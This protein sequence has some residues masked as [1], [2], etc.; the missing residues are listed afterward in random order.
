MVPHK[1]LINYIQQKKD[2]NPFNMQVTPFDTV[3]FLFSIA[4]NGK[5][6]SQLVFAFTFLV[7]KLQ[8]VLALYFLRCVMVGRCYFW[9]PLILSEIQL[10]AQNYQ[11][12]LSLFNILLEPD[13]YGNLRGIFF[14]GEPPS[15]ALINAW[16]CSTRRIFN[17]YGSTK[18][19]CALLI[20]ELLPGNAI[21]FGLRTPNS[22]IL[23]LDSD[24]KLALAGEICIN[25]SSLA[26]G[27]FQNKELTSQK[28][29]NWNKIQIY[30]T[31]D[32]AETLP[33]KRNKGLSTLV[34][35]TP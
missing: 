15:Q 11:P 16:H 2:M 8:Q 33:S 21:T 1:G 14:G 30:R 5:T 29:C 35:R 9:I 31:R 26:R 6:I 24:M 23:L 3:F 12:T 28:F 20:V 27:Y 22:G 17:C 18:T 34:E 25:G 19:T 4:F 10:F 32:I 13:R 7:D